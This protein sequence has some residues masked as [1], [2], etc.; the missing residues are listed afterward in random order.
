MDFDGTKQN[1]TSEKD[2]SWTTRRELQWENEISCDNATCKFIE[3]VIH[4]DA[5]IWH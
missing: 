5:L 4:S 1:K 3:F 2:K